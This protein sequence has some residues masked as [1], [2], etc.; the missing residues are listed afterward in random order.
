MRII[1]EFYTNTLIILLFIG[2]ILP[3]FSFV[4]AQQGVIEAPE[5]FEEAKE[6]GKGFLGGLPNIF[7]E[8]WQKGSHIAIWMY[9]KAL[10]IWNSYIFPWL[11]KY[12]LQKIEKRKPLIEEEFKKEKTEMKE[13]MK[14][15]VPRVGKSLWEKLKDLVR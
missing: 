12:L 13:E 7:K 9:Q 8:I 6:M 15:E 5:T 2:L 4:F 11:D 10:N 14:T 1:Y 3:S